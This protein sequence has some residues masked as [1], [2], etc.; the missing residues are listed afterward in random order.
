MV[1]DGELR[2]HLKQI[3]GLSPLRDAMLLASAGE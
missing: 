3:A 2:R 1:I